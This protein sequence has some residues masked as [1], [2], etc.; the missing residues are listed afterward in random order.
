MEKP[1][2][3]E[4]IYVTEGYPMSAVVMLFISIAALIIFI[5]FFIQFK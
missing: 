1:K 4:P 2:R 5:L 3:P